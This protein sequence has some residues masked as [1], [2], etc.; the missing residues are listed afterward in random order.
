MREYAGD[1]LVDASVLV[2]D[3]GFRVGNFI[4]NK[5]D[6]QVAKI[7]QFLPNFV[8]LT[9]AKGDRNIPVAAF[10][11]KEWEQHIIK[12]AKEDAADKQEPIVSQTLLN[13]DMQ[14][15]IKKAELLIRLR[16][17]FKKHEDTLKKVQCY[18]KPKEVKATY[19][20]TAGKLVLVPCGSI[21]ATPND[22]APK[23][24]VVMDDDGETVCWIKDPTKLPSDR[25]NDK[26]Y[27]VYP[28]WFVGETTEDAKVNMVMAKDNMYVPIMKN[29]KVVKAG[30]TLLLKSKVPC[31][32]SYAYSV[33][34]VVN[35]MCTKTSWNKLVMF[36]IVCVIKTRLHRG[37]VPLHLQALV[38]LRR[39]NKEWCD[40]QVPGVSELFDNSRVS[41]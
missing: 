21:S 11:N 24:A 1:S 15:G 16:D 37:E 39:R 22:K 14:V 6:K 27:V 17:T 25:D 36:S 5:K 40:I 12:P 41:H 10:Q 7:K 18:V 38:L 30:E 35:L 8:V 9:T 26:D 29:T 4:R 20:F 23:N 3:L 13:D 2:A 32:N 31:K 34:F 19:K 33:W 28:F